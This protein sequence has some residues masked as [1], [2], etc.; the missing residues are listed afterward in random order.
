MK[1]KLVVSGRRRQSQKGTVTITYL[2]PYTVAPT[3][4]QMQGANPNYTVIATV[5][6][7]AAAD[8]SA[9]ITH[10]FGLT[11]AE[12]TQGFPVVTLV[13]QDGN[14]ITSAWF[15]ASENPN[16]TILQKGTVAAGGTQ[17][18]V[19]QRPHTIGR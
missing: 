2:W 16:Y 19:I 3:A 11:A 4:A 1:S 9:V 6:A 5:S 12:I 18:V 7:S 10:D 17:K 8:T 15:E 14:E 13:P